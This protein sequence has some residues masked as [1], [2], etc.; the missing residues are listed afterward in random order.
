MKTAMQNLG[1]IIALDTQQDFSVSNLLA[2]LMGHKIKKTRI[3]SSK[4]K[5]YFFYFPPFL[6]QK[7]KV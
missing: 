3:F 4:L 5:L 7:K 6:S 2:V 1:G